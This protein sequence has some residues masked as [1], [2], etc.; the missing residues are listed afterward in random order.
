[1]YTIEKNMAQK[2]YN[3]LRDGT[4]DSPYDADKRP[5]QCRRAVHQ[6]EFKSAF[7]LCWTIPL[8]PIA[9]RPAVMPC[10]HPEHQGPLSVVR[11]QLRAKT[12]YGLH[13][14]ELSAVVALQLAPFLAGFWDDK[15]TIAS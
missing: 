4:W 5:P 14:V 9:P 13:A 2:N 15:H 8:L 7:A 10:R 1:M 3:Y 12:S 6:K 11:Q